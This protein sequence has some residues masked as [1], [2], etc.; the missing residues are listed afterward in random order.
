M[1]NNNLVNQQL[2]EYAERVENYMHDILKSMQKKTEM[3]IENLFDAMQYSLTAGGK[4]I[5]PALIY[6]FC[7]ACGGNLCSADTVACAMEMTHT[8]SL[9]FDDLPAMDNDDFRRGK[10]SCHKAFGEATAILAGDALICLPFALIAESENLNAEQKINLIK[11]LAECEGVSGMIGG[12]ML[13]MQFE[14]QEHVKLEELQ[15]M[16]LGKTGALMQASC[17]M[18]CLCGNATQEQIQA[19]IR[20]GNCVG[21]A[22]QII[23]DILDVTSTSEQLGKPVGSDIEKNKTTFVTILGIEE[24]KKQATELTKLAHQA[25]DNFENTEFLHA[26]TDA[27]LVRVQ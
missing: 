23:D 6:A 7:Q 9:I 17:Q 4:R 5:R 8:S 12:Q 22:F 14:N 25:L 20:Y 15:M 21:L 18:G 1:N 26:L 19:S 11:T 13:D 27:L 10:P 24:A 3:P 2:A 16:C